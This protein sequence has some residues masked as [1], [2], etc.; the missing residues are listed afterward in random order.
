MH[1]E[2][3]NIEFKKANVDIFYVM[4]NDEEDPKSIKAKR[5]FDQGNWFLTLKECRYVQSRVMT[6]ATAGRSARLY[7]SFLS[8]I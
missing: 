2:T 7:L 8:P 5:V 3:T 4:D 1:A 6:G